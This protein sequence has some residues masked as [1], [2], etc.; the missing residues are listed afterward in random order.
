[1]LARTSTLTHRSGFKFATPLLVP[2]F[3]SKG[4]LFRKVGDRQISE[5]TD[6]MRITSEVLT[7]SF[8]ISAY[9][10]YNNH[11]DPIKKIKNVAGLAGLVFIDSGGYEISDS[12]DFSAI[13]RHPSPTDPNWDEEKLVDVISKWP[14]EYP[15]VI[16]SFDY[17]GKPFAKQIGAARKFFESYPDQ[18]HDFIV[19]PDRIRNGLNIDIPALL[20]HL[21]E[22]AAFD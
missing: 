13:F 9:D 21:K 22:L 3:S 20:P 6:Y 19:K 17:H 18:M 15:S 2:S 10:L 5:V 4:F 7:E 11:I 12:H 16:V 14:K 1:M 8:L